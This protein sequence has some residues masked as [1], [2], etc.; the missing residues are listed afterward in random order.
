MGK[1]IKDEWKKYS[2]PN[3]RPMPRSV[4][5]VRKNRNDR[6]PVQRVLGPHFVALGPLEWEWRY[7]TP[8]SELQ[9]KYKELV[10]GKLPELEE[11]VERVSRGATFTVQGMD[12]LK[13]EFCVFC[14]YDVNREDPDDEHSPSC[15]TTRA[16]K[17]TE[18]MES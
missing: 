16:R 6:N 12:G 7:I 15:L 14:S 9:V 8:P 11:I 13:H 5:E 4:V 17:L 3:C 1:Q 18:S 2:Y 10:E